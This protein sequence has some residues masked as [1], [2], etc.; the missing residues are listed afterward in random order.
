MSWDNW[1]FFQEK[2]LK[3]L[4]LNSDFF[5]L[6]CRNKIRL[7]FNISNNININRETNSL[8][9]YE[10]IVKNVLCEINDQQGWA[11]QNHIVYYI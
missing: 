11:K 6:I 4:F 8:I 1:G 10:Q 3:L 9:Y 7:V 5:F 2:T